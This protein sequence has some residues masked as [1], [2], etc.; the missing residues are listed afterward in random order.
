[1]DELILQA[2]TEEFEKE[3][4]SSDVLIEIAMEWEEFL[5]EYEYDM[6]ELK[7]YILKSMILCLLNRNRA[8]GRM[9]T[10]IPLN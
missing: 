6:K 3:F 2:V 10:Q 5:Q 1:M 8:M 4:Y 7:P 9:I